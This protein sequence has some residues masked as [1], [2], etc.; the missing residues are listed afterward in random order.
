MRSNS[1]ARQK[2]NSLRFVDEIEVYLAYQVKLRDRLDLQLIAPDMRFYEVSYV[3]EHDLT[4]AETQVRNQ[5]E[6][7]FADYLA[8]SLATLGDGGEPDRP[9]SPCTDAGPAQ[10]GDGRGVS[11]TP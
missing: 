4:A 3:T 2:V 11:E 10:G 1:I 9:R 5:E 6:A 8:N 7:G